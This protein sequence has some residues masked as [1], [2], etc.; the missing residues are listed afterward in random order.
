MATGPVDSPAKLF[1]KLIMDLMIYV[2]GGDD[3]PLEV[4]PEELRTGGRV[5]GAAWD[6]VRADL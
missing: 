1:M 6:R 5:L 2:P 4:D 3:R